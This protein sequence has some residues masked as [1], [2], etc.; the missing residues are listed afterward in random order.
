MELQH[1]P[2]I[3]APAGAALSGPSEDGAFP[4]GEGSSSSRAPGFSRQQLMRQLPHG[5][6]I[7]SRLQQLSSVE[8]CGAALD[9]RL[10]SPGV[11][12]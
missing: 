8:F 10:L 12:T 7:R 3:P 1:P 5:R 6:S 11:F 9:L 4:K 2:T